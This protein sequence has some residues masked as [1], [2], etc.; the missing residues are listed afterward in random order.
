MNERICQAPDCG[1]SIAHKAPQARYCDNACNQRAVRAAKSDRR[2]TCQGSLTG[3][4]GYFQALD[5]KRGYLDDWQPTRETRLMIGRVRNILDE[6]RAHLPLTCRQIYYRMIAEWKY[7]KGE[8][9][10]RK[11][12]DA[13]VDARRAG[14]IDFD[15]IRDDGI[16]EHASWWPRGAVEVLDDLDA[17]AR[18]FRRDMQE[19]QSVRIQVW[20]ESAGM[21][22]QLATIASRYSIPVYSCGGFLSL[23]AIRTI[24]DSCLMGDEPTVLLHLSDCDP[25]GYS[26]FQAIS[27]DVAAFLAED[28]PDAKFTAER[29][30]LTLEQ[31][32]ELDVVPDDVPRDPKDTRAAAWRKQGLTHQAQLE[33]LAPDRIAALLIEA[34][35]RH[36]DAEAMEI[37]KLMQED[38]RVTLAKCATVARE[39]FE[40]LT[41]E[42]PVRVPYGW[43]P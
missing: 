39:E 4:R 42:G 36:M 10:K 12:Y 41:G 1:K 21:V 17:R 29:V 34:I 32:D 7:S 33:A 3:E 13:L 24:V 38:D 5:G 31:L 26:I 20:C 18:R 27:E 35:E 11:L 40:T 43:Q 14:E 22:P 37:V 19:G 8:K 23:T 2:A 6:Y 30:A 28:A 16:M 9:F 25:S 15:D